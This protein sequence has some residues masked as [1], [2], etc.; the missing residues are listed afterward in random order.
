MCNLLKLPAFIGLIC[1][2]GCVQTTRH[3]ATEGETI[4]TGSKQMAKRNTT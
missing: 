4:R 1:L 2:A 3:L